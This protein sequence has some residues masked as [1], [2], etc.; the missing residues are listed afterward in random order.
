[1]DKLK[2]ER[3]FF[4]YARSRYKIHLDRVAGL[5]WPWT[6]DPILQTYRFCNIFREDDTVTK[7]IRQ[8]TKLKKLGA[9]GVF[10]ATVI[11][12]WFNRIS[13]LEVLDKAGL[14]SYMTWNSTVAEA[15]LRNIRP[16]VNAA[17]I[18]SSPGGKNKLEGILWCIDQVMDDIPAMANK[19]TK[20]T[21]LE[22]VHSWLV[23]YPWLGKFMAYEVVTDLR[24]NLLRAAPD[25]HT[26]AQPGPGAKRG[27]GRV[28]RG[29]PYFYAKERGSSGSYPDKMHGVGGEAAVMQ[30]MLRLLEASR[31]SKN[32]WRPWP[33]W[34]MREVEHTLCEFDKYERARLGEGRP[35][36]LYKRAR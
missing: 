4:A 29:D 3:A 16:V 31:D 36:Q 35:K 30:G 15:R 27:F 17:Y 10:T 13:T 2:H 6:G 19:I 20:K 25:I 12:R 18:I 24:H 21:T 23:P 7:W 11:A 9:E 5:G 26:W 32:W 33:I 14:L 22:E 8:R 34:E 1:M 28:E